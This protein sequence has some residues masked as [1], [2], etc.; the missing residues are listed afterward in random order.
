MPTDLPELGDL[1]GEAGSDDAL[2]DDVDVVIEAEELDDHKTLGRCVGSGDYN[3][4]DNLL[5][6]AGF[7]LVFIRSDQNQFNS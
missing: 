1:F 5:S 6:Q 7:N 2:D 4:C 3:S